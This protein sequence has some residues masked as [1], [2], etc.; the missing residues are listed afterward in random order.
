MECIDEL[1]SDDCQLVISHLTSDGDTA[2]ASGATEKQGHVIENLRDL[3][4]FF[5]IWKVE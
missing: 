5:E 3:H 2:A 1:Q 4:H